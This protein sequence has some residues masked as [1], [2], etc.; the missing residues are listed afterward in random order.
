MTASVSGSPRVIGQ[1]DSCGI[2]EIPANAKRTRHV[3]ILLL[4]HVG[5]IGY[6][7]WSRSP[8]L[9]EMGHLASGLHH[10]EAHNFSLYAVNPPLVRSLAVLPVILVGYESDWSAN[11]RGVGN[12]QEFEIGEDFLR[13]NG[14]RTAY[15]VT[16]ARWMCIPFSVLGGWTCYRWATDLFCHAGGVFSCT[17]WCFSPTIIGHASLIT[18][19]AHA[20]ALGT[21]A[22]YTFWRWLKDPTWTRTVLTGIFLGLAELAKSTMIILFPLWPAIWLVYRW[23][24]RRRAESLIWRREATMLA[25]RMLIGL[26][27][28]NMGYC[29]EGSFL[30]LSDFNFVSKMFAGEHRLSKEFSNHLPHNLHGNRFRGTCI[31]GVPVPFPG[32]Y[33]VGIDLQQRDFEDFHHPSYLR[34]QFRDSGWWYYYLYAVLV[35]TPLGTIALAVLCLSIR[36]QTEFR[37]LISLLSPAIVI[38][39]V[40][41]SKT[42]INHHSRYVLPCVPFVFVW[43]GQLGVLFSSQWPEA[44]GN[45]RP[46]SVAAIVLLLWSVGSSLASY[47]HG[48]SYFNELAG[49]P[50]CG[51]KHLIHSNIDWGQD[52]YHLRTAI[53]RDALPRPVYLAFYNYYNPFDL[54]GRR[55]EPWPLRDNA[56]LPGNDPPISIPEGSYAISVNLLYGYHWPVRNLDGSRYYIDNQ[57]LVAL[58]RQ[59]PISRA[60]YSIYI[61]SSH[62]IASAYRAVKPRSHADRE[63]VN[64]PRDQ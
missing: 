22:C 42:G 48:L 57:P 30:P 26:S 43:L 24:Q 51:P 44:I 46:Y 55:V 39:L 45:R 23:K 11:T 34:G 7:G 8:T 64:T 3:A 13:A 41:S 9:N 31:E 54:I 47:P 38:F 29:F 33:V 63:L 53:Q 1:S 36:Q 50:K 12:R 27:V 18:P 61:Y 35:K 4:L 10:W 56:D 21:F 59:E 17:L 25:V 19:D 20:T 16:L 60:G 49:G 52:L 37:N 6:A 62:Q 15:L 2:P 28:L 14:A 58:R 40:V 5:L 32:N